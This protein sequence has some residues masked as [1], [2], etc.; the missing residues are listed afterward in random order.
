MIEFIGMIAFWGLCLGISV[1]VFIGVKD[2]IISL[3]ESADSVE[4]IVF[5]LS[6]L[7]VL[8]S[9]IMLLIITTIR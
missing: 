1:I 7:L 3:I 9:A 8:I 4:A 5:N 2:L 6:V